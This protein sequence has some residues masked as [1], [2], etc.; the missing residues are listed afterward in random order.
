MAFLVLKTLVQ[1]RILM[2]LMKQPE[3]EIS[4]VEVGEPHEV[5]SAESWC[6]RQVTVSTAGWP[7]T[8]LFVPLCRRKEGLTAHP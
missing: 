2:L 6:E 8:V 3:D 4:E 7:V 5:S 1:R